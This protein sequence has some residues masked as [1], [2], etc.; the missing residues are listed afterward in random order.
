MGRE[1]K[2]VCPL[3]ARGY[4]WNLLSDLKLSIN[5]QG[6]LPL[7]TAQKLPSNADFMTVST[8]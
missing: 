4:G 3:G 5:A 6:H 2:A 8:G 1:G 7:S